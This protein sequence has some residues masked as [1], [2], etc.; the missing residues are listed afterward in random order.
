[1][2]T[3]YETTITKY[4]LLA[5]YMPQ[6]TSSEDSILF[7]KHKKLNP[8]AVCAYEG[9]SQTAFLQLASVLIKA[10]TGKKP[11]KVDEK[12]ADEIVAEIFANKGMEERKLVAAH[13]LLLKEECV[14][15]KSKTFA[16]SLITAVNQVQEIA[17][18][19]QGEAGAGN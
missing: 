9:M 18:E 16:K 3:N 7:V 19:E 6:K 13:G 15:Q 10:E 11:N 1:M 8:A 5:G 12:S 4:A 14:P 17:K 2:K